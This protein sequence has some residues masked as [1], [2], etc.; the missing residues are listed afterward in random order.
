METR[1]SMVRFIR[2]NALYD[3][4]TVFKVGSKYYGVEI[5]DKDSDTIY[6]WYYA[7]LT[8]FD[9]DDMLVLVNL[10]LDLD[11]FLKFTSENFEVAEECF[12]HTV[13]AISYGRADYYD[14]PALIKV[15]DLS[16]RPIWVLGIKAT[17]IDSFTSRY[18]LEKAGIVIQKG[19]LIMGELMEAEER[20]SEYGDLKN[21]VIR[22]SKRVYDEYRNYKRAE[23]LVEI[24]KKIAKKLID[25]F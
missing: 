4:T 18:S 9:D 10:D 16:N 20:L 24:G 11:P 23:V 13:Q 1:Y 2:D 7:N 5:R 17:D 15:N 21:T 25:L 6:T 22:L 14:E 19:L 3:K 12:P 8:G